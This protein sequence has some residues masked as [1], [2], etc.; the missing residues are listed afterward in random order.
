MSR[1]KQVLP[2]GAACLFF[3]Q[4]RVLDWLKTNPVDAVRAMRQNNDAMVFTIGVDNREDVE[5][6]FVNVAFDFGRV[7]V[8]VEQV[9]REVFGGL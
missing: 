5:V 2:E 9:V 4:R 1:P 6:V 3:L 7:G 8:V